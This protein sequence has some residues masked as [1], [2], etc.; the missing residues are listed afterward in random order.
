MAG[1]RVKTKQTCFPSGWKWGVIQREKRRMKMMST[2]MGVDAGAVLGVMAMS[3]NVDRI[4]LRCQ[5]DIHWEMLCRKL[6]MQVLSS[7]ER[8]GLG[9]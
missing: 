6:Y 5:L 1:S 8:C 2:D 3:L 4:N 7:L 9:F